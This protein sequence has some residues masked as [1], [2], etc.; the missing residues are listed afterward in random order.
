MIFLG[1]RILLT[2]I[3]SITGPCA[4]HTLEEQRAQNLSKH[5]AVLALDYAT[6][7]ALVDAFEIREPMIP[8]REEEAPADIGQNGW[9]T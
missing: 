8:H 1:A 2:R 5:Q 3:W 9:Y 4:A 7:R 6:W